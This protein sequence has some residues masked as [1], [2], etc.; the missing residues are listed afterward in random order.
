MHELTIAEAVLD[1]ALRHAGD[2]RVRGVELRVGHLRQVVPSA[3]TFAWELVV[4]GTAADGAELVLV[5]VPAA[6]RCRDCATESEQDAFPLR[7]EAC[8]GYAVDVVRGEEL[9]VDSLDVETSEEVR[10]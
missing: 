10:V 3:L 7:C 2:R 6:V 4:Q 9:L 5:E 1:V 8:G